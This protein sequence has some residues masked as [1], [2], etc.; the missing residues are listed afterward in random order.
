MSRIGY[1]FCL[2]MFAVCAFAKEPEDKSWSKAVNGIRAKITMRERT[3]INGTRIIS[4]YLNLQNV[5]GALN[6][7]HVQWKNSGLS[8]KVIDEDGN[9][10]PRVRYLS[11]NGAILQDYEV[12]LPIDSTLTFRVSCSGHGIPKNKVAF[13][14]FGPDNCWAIDNADGRKYFLKAT[15]TMRCFWKCNKTYWPGTID[16]PKAE[17]PLK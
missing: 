16:I 6:P 7:L 3:V 11:Y 12:I 4:V 9:E 13:L 8:W 14:D 5:S 15:L 2:V 17:I 10:L 1:V